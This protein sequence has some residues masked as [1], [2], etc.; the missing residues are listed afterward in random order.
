M[1]DPERRDLK[2]H[3]DAVCA[4]FGDLASERERGLLVANLRHD[5]EVLVV[6]RGNVPLDLARQ[7]HQHGTGIAVA[8]DQRV[9]FLSHQDQDI[10]RVRTLS[11]SMGS[12]P[13]V[14]SSVGRMQGEIEFDLATAGVV[15]ADS[16]EPVEEVA[17]FADAV[18]GMFLE[19]MREMLLSPGD[20]DI[21]VKEAVQTVAT[22][23]S[24]PTAPRV[25]V[26]KD[27]GMFGIDRNR[28]EAA[29]LRH[30]LGY[31]EP[32]LHAVTGDF[33]LGIREGVKFRVTAHTD[34]LIVATSQRLLF[35]RTDP[36][37]ETEGVELAMEDLDSARY[38]AGDG[39]GE[40]GVTGSTI[41]FC[42]ISAVTSQGG[43][44]EFASTLKRTLSGEYVAVSKPYLP[45]RGNVAPLIPAPIVSSQ[46]NPT[47][48]ASEPFI[49]P[50][51]CRCWKISLCVPIALILFIVACSYLF[52]D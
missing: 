28:P 8:T 36:S 39:G 47:E 6:L 14:S 13:K 17:R 51:L 50:S 4:E 48:P 12:F 11:V 7:H 40:I 29:Y 38:E 22:A 30:L 16:L 20:V 37:G 43:A 49:P 26:S 2:A 41:A 18:N 23:R 34:A 5:E 52:V 21:S 24:E 31:G 3:V 15:R 33:S 45:K 27:L 1:N 19:Q 44:V 10:A 42:S 25:F 32:V 46:D 9:L 35:L